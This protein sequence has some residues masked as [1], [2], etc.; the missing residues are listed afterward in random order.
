MRRRIKSA[1]ALVLSVTL[2]AGLGIVSDLGKIDAKAGSINLTDTGANGIAYFTEATEV[3][4]MSNGGEFMRPNSGINQN[5]GPLDFTCDQTVLG[6]AKSIIDSVRVTGNWYSNFATADDAFAAT[7][8]SSLYDSE[9]S[10][11]VATWTN[12]VDSLENGDAI[13]DTGGA[14]I[15]YTVAIKYTNTDFKDDVYTKYNNAVIM[16][17]TRYDLFVY[18]AMGTGPAFLRFTG[19]KDSH[20]TDPKN[21]RKGGIKWINKPA[22]EVHP[23]KK[24]SIRKEVW[25]NGSIRYDVKTDSVYGEDDYNNRDYNGCKGECGRYKVVVREAT[26]GTGIGNAVSF[27]SSR[28][29]G[30]IGLSDLD[31]NEGY[32]FVTDSGTNFTWYKSGNLGSYIKSSSGTL[33]SGYTSYVGKNTSDGNDPRSKTKNA[34]FGYLSFPAS[35]LV[36]A[37]GR[38]DNYGNRGSSLTFDT[39]KSD[40]SYNVTVKYDKGFGDGKVSEANGFLTGN[41]IVVRM[42]MSSGYE[43]DSYDGISS[44]TLVE[45]PG[46]YEL[47]FIMPDDNVTI[48]LYSHYRINYTKG[49]T[50]VAQPDKTSGPYRTSSN[51]APHGA[52]PA[53]TLLGASFTGRTYNITYSGKPVAATHDPTGMPA[54]VTGNLAA[55]DWGEGVALSA[56][57]NPGPGPVTYTQR[58]ESHKEYISSTRPSLH[59]WHFTGWTP[60]A[61]YSTEPA[62]DNRQ[63]YLIEEGTSPF[64]ANV[65]ANFAENKYL[66]R[67]NPNNVETDIQGKKYARRATGSMSDQPI[68]YDRTY[69]LNNNQFVR[70]G[71]V[72]EGWGTYLGSTTVVYANGATIPKNFVDGYNSS[73]VNTADAQDTTKGQ[74]ITL[75][76]IWSPI[77]YDVVIN[78]NGQHRNGQGAT[79]AHKKSNGTFET[80]SSPTTKTY[81]DWGN[82]FLTVEKPMHVADDYNYYDFAGWSYTMPQTNLNSDRNWIVTEQQTPNNI[83]Q[84]NDY[85]KLS[86]ATPNDMEFYAP[87]PEYE[88]TLQ[89]NGGTELEPLYVLW[90]HTVECNS[91]GLIKTYLL[92]DPPQDPPKLV[93]ISRTGYTFKGWCTDPGCNYLYNT[94][95]HVK[96]DFTLYAKWQINTYTVTF[97]G[98][99]GTGSA[100]QTVNYGSK[101]SRPADPVTTGKTFGG[102]FTDA[103]CTTAYDFN[104]VITGNKILYAKWT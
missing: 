97:D 32:A 28:L 42:E 72:F 2:L 84:W 17:D 16:G 34:L 95:T 7:T 68:L 55:K 81:T 62:P 87:W 18:P 25:T 90:D 103:T 1:I 54:N 93:A 102:W 15:N 33:I 73:L 56:S 47:S 35:G 44:G 46:Y 101:A 3:H 36:F 75:Y 82:I 64:S 76:A 88:I 71:Y 30:L 63:Y 6:D 22:F 14:K 5:P 70:K 27:P 100:T 4:F 57:V 83:A 59:G 10:K 77:K 37:Y 52:V 43:F 12:I 89:S 11:T 23:G 67:F 60:Q 78:L 45:Y 9:N 98:N 94:T 50:D 26:P 80:I 8:A 31:L 20:Q 19:W 61:G 99:G 53:A 40:L 65:V 74:V 79:W 104:N 85:L 69:N 38:V 48:N 41:T 21:I 39:V 24:F 86:T 49:A 66:I 92:T 96:N 91:D 29:T 58:Y 13:P 51:G